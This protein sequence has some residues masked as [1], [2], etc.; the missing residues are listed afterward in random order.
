MVGGPALHGEDPPTAAGF[1]ASAARPYTVSVGMATSPPARNTSSARSMIAHSG[2][3]SRNSRA[4]SMNPNASGV[5][6]WS[7][8]RSVRRVALG[9]ASAS[10]SPGPGEVAIADHDQRRAGHGGQHLRLKR[11]D[12]AASSPRSA[13]R[14]RCP[15][16]WRTA[17]TSAPGCRR[18]RRGPRERRRCA[19][20][21]DVVGVEQRRAD[22]GEHQPVE[23][24][25]LP[26]SRAQ[27]R[28]R[29]EREADRIDRLVGA[30]RRHAG[31]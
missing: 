23:A 7:T 31:R 3:A 8:L 9:S 1:D 19:R 11:V 26:R 28:D 24:F 14:C 20:V 21:R 6:K 27:Q 2:T 25:R 4:A 29:A 5:A 12:A 15:V 30:W 22:A 13:R 17:R 10:G 16:G 18:G